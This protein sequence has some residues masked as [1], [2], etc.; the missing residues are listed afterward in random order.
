MKKH[1]D[2]TICGKVQGVTFRFSARIIAERMGIVGY[3]KNQDDG[4]VFIEAEGEEG[5]LG[6]FI[7]WCRRGP[8]EA[9]VEKVDVIYSTALKGYDKFESVRGLK[10]P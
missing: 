9:R 6:K 3:A 4:T 7:D 1:I 10:T 5:D 2:I 8:E